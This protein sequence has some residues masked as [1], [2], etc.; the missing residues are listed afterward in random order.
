MADVKPIV[1][2]GGVATLDFDAE[3]QPL[4]K[5]YQLQPKSMVDFGKA[6]SKVEEIALKYN[7]KTSDLTFDLYYQN[8]KTRIVWSIPYSLLKEISGSQNLNSDAF[9]KYRLV[10]DVIPDGGNPDASTSKGDQGYLEISIGNSNHV[11]KVE[12]LHVINPYYFGK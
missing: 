3:W 5:E 8:S 11:G 1:L 4:L 2:G 6:A 10:T 12:K 7:K 9:D